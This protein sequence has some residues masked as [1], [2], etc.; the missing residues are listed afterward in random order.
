MQNHQQQKI[1]S[2]IDIFEHLLKSIQESWSQDDRDILWKKKFVDSILSEAKWTNFMALKK[3]VIYTTATHSNKG[4]QYTKGIQF[5]HFRLFVALLGYVKSRIKR[6]IKA[7]NK[8]RKEKEKIHVSTWK[9]QFAE[10]GSYK[11][12]KVVELLNC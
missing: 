9:E 4:K 7:K 11:V 6:C 5:D 12:D 3:D 10:G 8:G 2:D 1:L